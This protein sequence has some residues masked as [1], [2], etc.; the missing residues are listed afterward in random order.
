MIDEKPLT[1][2]SN[3]R[4]N[5][6]I[7]D[8][9][10]V[11]L[12]KLTGKALPVAHI[13]PVA[14]N[15]SPT[16]TWEGGM[17]PTLVEFDSNFALTMIEINAKLD[18]LL[19]AQRGEDETARDRTPARLSMNQLL[20]RIN[21]KLDHLLGTQHLSRQEDRIRLDTVSLSAS[22]IKLTTEESFSPGD[23]VELRML[24]NINTPF[25]IVV[26]GSVVRATALPTGKHE[27]AINFADMDEAIRD[28]ISR[29]ALLTQKK[30]LLA[31]RGIPS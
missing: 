10:P 8:V 12:R 30:Q 18:L 1:S 6:R 4:E 25:W 14:I 23:L 5:F 9:L 22:G 27:V 13:F 28:E 16:G 21:L 15:S 20:L 2:G 7:D 24:M 3:R 11:S 31:R 17:S 29:Y 26:G 19:G